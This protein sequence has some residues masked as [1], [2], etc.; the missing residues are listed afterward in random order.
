MASNSQPTLV[1]AV[2]AG[3]CS[4]SALAALLLWMW[5][6]RGNKRGGKKDAPENPYEGLPTKPPQLP[7]TWGMGANMQLQVDEF[8]YNVKSPTCWE[9]NKMTRKTLPEYLRKV[10]EELGRAKTVAEQ[11][12]MG[13]EYLPKVMSMVQAALDEC[14]DTGVIMERT[15]AS[16]KWTEYTVAE[17]K[18]RLAL[19]ES[20]LTPLVNAVD[21]LST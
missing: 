13:K 20:L 6:T 14:S 18:K 7:K 16:K 3:V 21:R 1:I 11:A 2:V 8:F 10:N 5:W 12:K 4:L 17:Y 19:I 15:Q 9:F